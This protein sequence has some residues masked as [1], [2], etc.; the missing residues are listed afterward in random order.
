[1]NSKQKT[2]YKALKIIFSIALIAGGLT[3]VA[4]IVPMGGP[5]NPFNF[6]TLAGIAVE[7]MGIIGYSKTSTILENEKIRQA[8]IEHKKFIENHP[9][10]REHEMNKVHVSEAELK[11]FYKE[12]KKYKPTKENEHNM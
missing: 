5:F 4:G 2:L 3:L 11:N 9:H 7:G 6:I 10:H 8:K 12:L 1:M